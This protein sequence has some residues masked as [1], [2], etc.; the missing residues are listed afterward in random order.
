MNSSLQIRF[1]ARA[2]SLIKSSGNNNI[3]EIPPYKSFSH[4]YLYAFGEN[5]QRK[6][7]KIAIFPLIRDEPKVLDGYDL[8]E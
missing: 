3:W 4:C 1:T 8:W 2:A 7:K 6:V 5:F